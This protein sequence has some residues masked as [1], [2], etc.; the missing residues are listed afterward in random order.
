M[1]ARRFVVILIFLIPVAMVITGCASRA[2]AFTPEGC[3]TSV[4]LVCPT[5]IAQV[6]PTPNDWRR[7][8]SSMSNIVI[9]ID[10]GDKCSMDVKSLTNSDNAIFFD[11]VVHDQTYPNYMVGAVTLDEGKTLQ[12]LQDYMKYIGI[13]PWAHTV[14][15]EIVEPSSSTWHTVQVGSVPIYFLCFVQ[16]TGEVRTIGI[17]EPVTITH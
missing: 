12:D 2:P 11:I 16:S 13:P 14:V 6:K 10:P 9:T 8:Y 4:P 5:V 15:L 17:F 3:S 7:D 1:S